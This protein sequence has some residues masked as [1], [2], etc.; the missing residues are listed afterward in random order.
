MFA[1]C[2]FDKTNKR[3]SHVVE[4]CPIEFSQSL[5]FATHAHVTVS[6]HVTNTPTCNQ[7]ESLSLHAFT[8]CA[9]HLI[10]SSQVSIFTRLLLKMCN[11]RK[12]ARMLAGFFRLLRNSGKARASMISRGCKNKQASKQI[13]TGQQTN[14]SRCKLTRTADLTGAGTE[15]RNTY[16]ASLFNCLYQ[17]I[18]SVQ[19]SIQKQLKLYIE[20][21]CYL[22]SS[23]K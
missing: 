5:H 6:L 3:K 7:N 10:S 20:R 17:N 8:H 21:L 1:T 12:W 2:L 9:M 13:R 18:L 11:L 15:Q 16:S 23:S 22:Y 19:I 14:K 4:H